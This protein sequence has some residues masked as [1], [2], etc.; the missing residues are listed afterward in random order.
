MKKIY[1]ATLYIA[2]AI[3]KNGKTERGKKEQVLGY[4]TSEKLA[5]QRIEQIKTREYREY[6][7]NYIMRTDI[8][9]KDIIYYETRYANG[10]VYKETRQYNIKTIQLDTNYDNGYTPLF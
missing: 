7:H 1:A 6:Q 2:N 5:R 3:T 8:D 9:N 10:N 4:Y